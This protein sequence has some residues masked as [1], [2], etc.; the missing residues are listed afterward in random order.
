MTNR[1]YPLLV[2]GVGGSGTNLAGSALTTHEGV[3]IGHEH[4]EGGGSS[5]WLHAV[6]DAVVGARYPFPRKGPHQSKRVMKEFSPRFN[7]VVH[8][9]RCPVSNMAALTTHNNFSREFI[10]KASGVDPTTTPACLWGAKVWLH[11]NRHVEMYADVRIRVE[12]FEN[13]AA[14]AAHLC[15]LGKLTECEKHPYP[16]PSSSRAVDNASAASDGGN[17]S[18]GTSRSAVS[19]GNSERHTQQPTSA[20]AASPSSPSWWHSWWP[21][22][23]EVETASSGGGSGGGNGQKTMSPPKSGTVR[24]HHREHGSCSLREVHRLDPALA[25]EILAMATRYGYSSSSSSSSA[26]CDLG[27]QDDR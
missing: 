25:Q 7:T 12:D 10:W 6:N 11:W 24:G 17:G 15:T 2:T 27:I 4:I 16:S 3:T 18:G 26:N 8:Q 14:L 9:V 23:V 13:P 1:V 19:S 22:A 20:V 5:S 21:L